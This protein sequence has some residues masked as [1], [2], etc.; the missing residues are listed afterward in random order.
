MEKRTEPESASAPPAGSGAA[1]QEKTAEEEEPGSAEEAEEG[2]RDL[3]EHDEA[4]TD[5]EDA[6]EEES[7][8]EESVH[9][10][11]DQGAPAGGDRGDEAADWEDSR[12][13]VRMEGPRTGLE[14]AAG[15]ELGIHS[16][17][18]AYRLLSQV[19]DYLEQVEPHS[20]SPYLIKRVAS[21]GE[22]TLPEILNEL[23]RNGIGSFE[24]LMGLEEG[25]GRRN[26]GED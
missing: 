9:E 21:W 13:R 7:S 12:R 1:A 15:S 14:M 18:D 17:A 6:P 20:P 19:A 23:N 8:D 11:E 26:R 22:M 5:R 25:G 16:R 10:Q 24:A 3:Q 4:E 2:D